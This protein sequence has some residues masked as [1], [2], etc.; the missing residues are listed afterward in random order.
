MPPGNRL[1]PMKKRIKKI[2]V[3]CRCRH[4]GHAWAARK[5]DGPPGTCA[6]RECRRLNWDKPPHHRWGVRRDG[7]LPAKAAG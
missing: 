3:Y 6:N 5:K 1:P 4:C 7:R 2:V